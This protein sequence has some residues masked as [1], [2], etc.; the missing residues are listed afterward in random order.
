LKTVFITRN[1]SE[2]SIFKKTLEQAGLKVFGES[3]IQFS[4]I[5]FNE[6]PKVEWIFFYSKNGV[7]FFFEGIEHANVEISKNVKWGVI[8]PETGK[9]LTLKYNEPD[10]TGNGNAKQTASSFLEFAK[11]QNVLFVQAE[12]SLKS[13]Q[14][15]LKNDITAFDLVVYSNSP[16]KHINIPSSDFIVFTSPLNVKVY[17]EKTELEPSQKLIAIGQTTA[18]ALLELGNIGFEIA[19]SPSEIELAKV[20]IN[21]LKT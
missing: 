7:K 13:I 8:G 2:N 20:I 3:L 14:K 19:E 1:L 5:P 17:F 9:S 10:F 11:S 4:V 21:N 15:I 18:N 6:I 12:S 16:K